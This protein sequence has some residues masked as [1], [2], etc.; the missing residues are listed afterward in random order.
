MPFRC[1]LILFVLSGLFTMTVEAVS[2]PDLAR[3]QRMADDIVDAILDGDPLNLATAQGQRF[4][5]VFTDAVDGAVV[6]GTAIILHG[7]GFHPDWVDV[8]QPLRIGLPEHGWNTLSIQLPVLTKSAKYYDYVPVFPH[9]IP[10]IEAA[11]SHARKH[12]GRN[13]VLI[14]HSCG[15]HMAQHWFNVRGDAAVNQVD[16]Y[17][18]IGMGATDYG[19]AMV[20]PFGLETMRIPLFDIYGGR[21]FPAVRR[22]ASERLLALRAAGH[23]R[24]TQ[25]VVPEADHYF[26]DHG[27]AL[28]EA[29]VDW[30]K[31]F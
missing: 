29:I 13:V 21:D 25:I 8:V 20:E 22:F 4:L 26:V 30:L 12:A 7:R 2:Q 23:P 1:R 15:S 16:A 18:G 6:K 24:N 17:V 11:V 14:A 19:Q 31:V 9:A 5:G 27:D 10:R 3:E 28:L